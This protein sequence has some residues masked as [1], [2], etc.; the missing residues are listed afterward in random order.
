MLKLIYGP[1]GAG[2][3]AHLTELLRVDLEKG[4]RCFLLVPEQQAY[5][6]ERDFPALLP[7]NSALLFRVVSFSRLANAVF[8]TY[9]GVTQAS[10]SH[11]VRTLLMWES[12]RE[13][14]PLLGQYKN[15]MGS[16]ISLPAKLLQT[17]TELRMSDIDPTRLEE[18]AKKLPNGSPLQKKLSDL[19][20]ID[21]VFHGKIED[22]FGEDPAD[23]L[24]RLAKKLETHS[25]FENCHVYIDSFAGFTAQEYA[26][27]GQIMKQC[28]S[29]TVSLCTD[30]LRSDLPHFA[31]AK[32]T[33]ARL[34]KLAAQADLTV[35]DQVLSAPAQ[36]RPIALR[37][38]ERDL[39]D[40][41]IKKE[42][43]QVLSDEERSSVRLISC[44]NI[45]EEAECAAWNILELVQ[46]GMHY[47]D[48]AIVARD[49]E[50]YRGVLDAA[51]E[52]YHIPYFLSERTDLS[53]KPLFRLILSALHAVSRGY[54][55]RD[56]ITLVKTG[57]AGVDIKDAS[58]F[59]EYCETWHINGSRFSDEIWSMNPDGFTKERS[60]RANEILDRA[61]RTRK[62]VM[63]PLLVLEA[64][65]RAS[66]TVS[67]RCRALY[68]YLT[69]L[70]ISG[71]LSERARNELAL[72]QK[73]DAEETLRLWQSVT[74]A[75]A[76]LA[77]LL[78]ESTLSVD[79]F[80]TA[81]TLLFSESDL[82]SVPNTH[83]C[84][85]IG[86]APTLR[87]ENVK[88]S[89]LLGLCDG[90]FP[91]ALSDD[92]ILSEADKLTLEGYDIYLDSREKIRSN[93]E[94]LYVYRAVSKPT[95]KLFLLTATSSGTDS[96]RAP[97]LAFTRAKYLLDIKN[98]EVF[99]SSTVKQLMNEKTVA[100]N[101]TAPQFIKPF[102][103]GTVL[104]LSQTKMKD[105]V[106][107]PYRYY[108]TYILKNREVKDSS[109]AYSDDGLFLH[110]IFECF[111][112]ASRTPDGS[113]QLPSS[114]QIEALA[115]EIINDYLHELFPFALS[116]M[117]PHRLHSF[118][119]LRKFAIK[120]LEEIV[121]EL[122]SAEFVPIRFEQEIG[123]DT[124][125]SL[126][127]VQF[128]LS[129][130]SQALLRGTIDRVD[131]YEADGKRYVRVID[132]KSGTGYRFSP[133]AV[134]DGT[135]MQL[136]LYLHALLSSDPSL[137]AA[138]AQ[139][140]YAMSKNKKITI[141]RS[142]FLLNE[143]AV[144]TAMDGSP[145]QSYLV[146]LDPHSK[147]S[148]TL[149][150]NDMEQAIVSIAER[151]LSGEVQKQPSDEA[152]RFCPIRKHCDKSYTSKEQEE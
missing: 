71:K 53:T 130:N 70:D 59:E 139:Y 25:Y 15:S 149:L 125:D 137:E 9:G 103:S 63:E 2:K 45:Y 5:I 133:D 82:G 73:R 99:H 84:V 23:K 120:M 72:G 42:Q 102:P 146:G 21:S 33:A 131:L 132:Y 8:R 101:A 31:G 85:I 151:I 95:Q 47:G 54:L 135:D 64:S 56:V 55:L 119:R 127:P 29:M 150:R 12:L 98:E 116:E 41:S 115:D 128:S 111:L 142:G 43:R 143:D 122:R 14:S 27:L 123:K 6:S 38:L 22:C 66:K 36:D 24:L 93:E 46:S 57:L 105:F 121:G 62:T 117:A 37:V 107:C 13:L 114:E 83:D 88:A 67:Q 89:I 20:L 145:N 91:R 17:V 61:N 144:K 94:M 52:R 141:C 60:E 11:G 26:V 112:R 19:A 87:V 109:P 4:I 65:M 39:W 106:L 129:N 138:G 134:R 74:E 49:A 78:P 10:V 40:F 32:E 77:E 48:I 34:T 140:L 104:H 7:R 110:H 18:I 86:S 28:A 80:S 68:A 124:P 16:D 92:G 3:T 147:E 113:F 118:Y 126:P 81:L 69:A 76:T 30:N 152:C 108:S 97:S 1:S 58:L 75:L 35:E 79:E 100:S 96:D 50:S 51:L 136:V 44:P 90:E 148:I